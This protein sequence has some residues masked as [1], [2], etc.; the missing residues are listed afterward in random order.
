MDRSFQGL[1]SNQIIPYEKEIPEFRT[2]NAPYVGV[3]NTIT[4]ILPKTDQNETRNFEFFKAAAYYPFQLEPE[5]I[6]EFA[7]DENCLIQL[8]Y[9]THYGYWTPRM[10]LSGLDR[11]Y[12]GMS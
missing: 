1:D 12:I 4:V 2:L 8:A 6:Q 9:S 11:V 5:P 7:H 3:H 10:L